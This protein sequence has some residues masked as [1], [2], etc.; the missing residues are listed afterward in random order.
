MLWDFH[1][2]AWRKF[3]FALDF[4][5]EKHPDSPSNKDEIFAV[6]MPEGRKT[7]DGHICKEFKNAE[8]LVK[9]LSDTEMP[10]AYA[11]FGL[12]YQ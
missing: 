9:K 12:T 10:E 8:V 4:Y 1:R 11:V 6:K 5:C 2:D 7:L 3:Y